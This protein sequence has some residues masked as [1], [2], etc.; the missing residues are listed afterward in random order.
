MNWHFRVSTNLT[1]QISRR[2]QEGF[3]EKSR[4]VCIASA[5]YAMYRIFILVCLNIE[6]IHDMHNMGVWQKT[7]KVKNSDQFLK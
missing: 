2:F 1:E 6:Q 7:A 5:C 4:N 3:Q